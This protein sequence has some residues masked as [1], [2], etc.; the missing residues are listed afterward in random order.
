MF[1]KLR[2]YLLYNANQNNENSISKQLREKRLKFFSEFCSRFEKPVNILD[3]GGS[4]YHWRN[5]EFINNKDFHITV[6]NTEEQNTK[7]LRNFSFIKRDVTDLKF[8]EDKEYDVVYSNSLLEHI[9]NFDEQRKLAEEVMRIG[10]HY[11]VQTPNYY[12]PVEPHFLFPFFQFLPAEMKV[13]LIKKYDLGWFKKEVDA[14]R[15]NELANSVRLLKERE[16][17]KIFPN[18]KIFYEKYFLL[19]KSFII[20]S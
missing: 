17:K 19:K 9:N 7:E 14:V 6:V 12:F 8:F 20:Y 2:S 4:D 1:G 10:R 18:G 5:S 15:A 16:L 11:F 3:L 13:N